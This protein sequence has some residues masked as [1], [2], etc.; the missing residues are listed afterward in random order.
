MRKRARIADGFQSA[1]KMKQYGKARSKTTDTG[2]P[3]LCVKG[4]KACDPQVRLGPDYALI[5][6]VRNAGCSR[7]KPAV[8]SPAALDRWRPR[9]DCANLQS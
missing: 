8:R 7:S 5:R 9:R 2:G 1:V 3:E 4:G 6:N